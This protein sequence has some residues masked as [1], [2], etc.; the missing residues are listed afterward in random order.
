MPLWWQKQCAH[1]ISFPTSYTAV[2]TYRGMYGW[3]RHWQSPN[4][5]KSIRSKTITWESFFVQASL[6]CVDLC[7]SGLDLQELKK[8]STL[9]SKGDH[10]EKLTSLRSP[11]APWAKNFFSSFRSR[12]IEH[13]ST[14]HG[15]AWTIKLF[16]VVSFDQIDLAKIELLLT[17]WRY[18]QLTLNKP[19]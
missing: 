3:H 15:D 14:H 10:S 7:S 16:H 5:A 1:R 11:F 12:P 4:L 17:I 9:E 8:I 19:F 13:G 18:W 2:H 6:W